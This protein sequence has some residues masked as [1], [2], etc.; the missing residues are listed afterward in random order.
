LLVDDPIFESNDTELSVYARQKSGVRRKL[1]F[2]GLMCIVGTA[3]AMLLVPSLR[4]FYEP[5]DVVVPAIA[6]LTGVG[7]LVAAGRPNPSLV[8]LAH[9]DR[10]EGTIRVTG[11]TAPVMQGQERVVWHD[12]IASIVFG[13]TR[14]EFEHK[15]GVTVEAFTVC[16]RLF[17]GSVLP[18]VEASPLKQELFEVAKA[19]SAVCHAPIEQAGLGA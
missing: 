15:K 19:L 6:V 16:L 3:V 18:I 2:W 13:L 9:V 4:N 8:L 17:D 12:E 14:Y 1:V 5:M 11:D 10:E 7:L